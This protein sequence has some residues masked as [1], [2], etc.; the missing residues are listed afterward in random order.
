VAR[1]RAGRAAAILFCAFVAFAVV[2]IG[3]WWAWDRT[4]GWPTPRFSAGEFVVVELRT[5]GPPSERWVVAV[6]P[7]CEHCRQSLADAERVR[8]RMT[9]PPRLEALVVDAP[10]PPSPEVFAANDL[11]AVWWDAHEVWRHRWGHRVYG[12]VLCFDPRG[13]Y[14]GTRAAAD[15][16][17]D[18]PDR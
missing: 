2:G 15:V 9:R 18:V 13:R 14:L 10:R 6:N 8:A 3:G 7:A 11:D 17:R 4:R 5:G 12:E 16:A 1:E